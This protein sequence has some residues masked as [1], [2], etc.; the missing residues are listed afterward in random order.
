[1]TGHLVETGWGAALG[2]PGLK[3]AQNGEIIEGHVLTASLD[4]FWSELDAFEGEHYQRVLARV[5]LTSGETVDAL[6]S[7]FR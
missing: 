1:M 7:A 3:R 4:T 2:Y 5:T 6:V